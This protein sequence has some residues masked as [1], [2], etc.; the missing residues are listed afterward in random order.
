MIRGWV[1]FLLVSCL[2]CG[3]V[4]IDTYYVPEP[5]TSRDHG[6]NYQL[7]IRR[8]KLNFDFWT[9]INKEK[10]LVFLAVR[11]S[12]EN[13]DIELNDI[14]I[15]GVD[16]GRQWKPTNILVKNWGDSS[17]VSVS[18]AVLLQGSSIEIDFDPAVSKDRHLKIYF[19]FPIEDFNEI[20]LNQV[21]RPAVLSIN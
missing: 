3:C 4:Y 7:F 9:S 8:D 17:Y 2:L 13:I 16:S 11:N 21:S 6:Q 19:N 10:F 20:E 1:L 12:S 18:H 5:P 15:V 14:N